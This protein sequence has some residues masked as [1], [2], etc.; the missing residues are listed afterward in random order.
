[1]TDAAR[2][3]DTLA[4][5]RTIQLVARA[6][7]QKRHRELLPR[8]F[9][10][11]AKQHYFLIGRFIDFSLPGGI[12]LLEYYHCRCYATQH[13]VAPP[14]I[15]FAG[16]DLARTESPVHAVHVQVHHDG[17]R[18]NWLLGGYYHDLMVREGDG[19]RIRDR[20]ARVTYENGTFVEDVRL[21]P[22]LA[23]Y[24]VTP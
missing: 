8:L 17:A 23:N 13:L 4:I 24:E 21:F 20:V 2:V 19:W 11:K 1:M 6:Y 5:T 15:E 12:D 16:R 9:V 22:T 10:E 14:T 3:E 18:S 7:D